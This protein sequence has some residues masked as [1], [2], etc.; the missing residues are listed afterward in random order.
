MRKKRGAELGAEGKRTCL[1]PS[2][3]KPLNWPRQ[4]CPTTNATRAIAF[5]FRGQ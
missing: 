4:N 5:G 1:P 3:A 2:R